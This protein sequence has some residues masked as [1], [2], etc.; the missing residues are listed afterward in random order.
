MSESKHDFS[1]EIA[2][3]LALRPGQVEA[4][5]ALLDEGNTIPFIARYRKEMT[6]ELDENQLRDVQER[7]TF[8]R[9]LASRKEEVHRLIDEQEKMTA[10]LAAAITGAKTLTELDDLY[11]PYRPKRKTRA[12]VARDKGLEPLKD[13]L[14][15]QP[16]GDVLA[17]AERYVSEER[18]GDGG[19]GFAG[20]T[21]YFRGG[22]VG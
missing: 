19:R 16:S 9:N 12:S 7:L 1:R 3:E 4:A 14:L 22:S 15:D 6:G 10:E 8:L 18:R 21:G 2:G 5:V 17:E 20:G 11:R 13:W